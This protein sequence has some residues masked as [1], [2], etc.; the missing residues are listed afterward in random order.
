[1][2]RRMLGL[3]VLAAVLLCCLVAGTP[4]NNDA[5]PAAE[6]AGIHL[7]AQ[8][9]APRIVGSGSTSPVP[10]IAVVLIV[11]AASCAV[12][13]RIRREV[14]GAPICDLLWSRSHSRRGPPI[15]F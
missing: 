15:R 4:V 9:T 7:S 6:I 10:M 11:A 14:T 8:P 5:S 1:M 12:S 13:S 3:V 2:Q